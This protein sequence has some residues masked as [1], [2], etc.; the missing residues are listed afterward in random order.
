MAMGEGTPE[1]YLAV[2]RMGDLGA[3]PYSSRLQ[4]NTAVTLLH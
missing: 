2:M 4:G 1:E 3:A